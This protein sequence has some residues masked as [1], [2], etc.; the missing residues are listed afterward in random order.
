M[1][2]AIKELGDWILSTQKKDRLNI[3]LESLYKTNQEEPRVL[4]IDIDITTTTQ[5]L[6]ISIKPYRIEK[7]EQYLYKRGSSRGANF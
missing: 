3:L 1:L 4:T 5:Y 6:E 7:I 2:E